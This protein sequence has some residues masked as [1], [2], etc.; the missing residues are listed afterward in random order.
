VTASNPEPDSHN[1]ST[2]LSKRCQMPRIRAYA[3]HV[4]AASPLGRAPT[5]TAGG[6]LLGG[7]LD[8]HVIFQGVVDRGDL[9]AG[10]GGEGGVVVDGALTAA[11]QHEHAQVHLGEA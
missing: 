6:W 5:A 3:L 10:A 7:A 11:G 4:A 9:E 1:D 8:D 2:G